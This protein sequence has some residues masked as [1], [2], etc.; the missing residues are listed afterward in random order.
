MRATP[1]AAGFFRMAA[2]IARRCADEGGDQARAD[3]A[4]RSAMRAASAQDLAM[5]FVD[6]DTGSV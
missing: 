2:T 1:D 3:A 5:T 4:P 6:I